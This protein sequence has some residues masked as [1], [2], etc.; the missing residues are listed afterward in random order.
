MSMELFVGRYLSVFYNERDVKRSCRTNFESIISLL[1]WIATIDAFQHWIYENPNHTPEQRKDAWLRI[2]GRFGD[3]FIDWSGLQL[4]HEY[5]WHQQLHIFQMPF[6]YIEY[7]IA[8]LGALGLWMQYKN[9]KAA[10][11]SNYRKAL[12][13]GGS[14][15]LPELFAAAGL[16]FDFSEKTI[17]PLIDAIEEEL[18]Q[19]E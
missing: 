4:Q 3:Q 9:D 15:P 17:A 8:Q 5:R 1:A 19:L 11:I 18:T 2:R 7:G 13:L 14:R 6:Y 16:K 10:A 12:A